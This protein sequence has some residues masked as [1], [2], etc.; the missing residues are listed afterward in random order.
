MKSIRAIKRILSIAVFVSGVAFY[1]L[2]ATA[3]PLLHNHPV[4]GKHHHSCPACNFTAI[5]SSIKLEIVISPDIFFQVVRKIF[6]NDQ[7]SSQQIF[8][9][10]YS[11][12]APP[13][14][15]A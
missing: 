6:L 8:C 15:F 7:E 9:K 12:R 1:L 3:H 11:A 2:F 4:D 14:I 13:Y 10:K 5:A